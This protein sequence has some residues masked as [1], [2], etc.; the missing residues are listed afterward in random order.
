MAPEWLGGAVQRLYPALCRQH[1]SPRAG[2]RGGLPV[3]GSPVWRTCGPHAPD[4]E[5]PVFTYI[6]A[7]MAHVYAP[8]PA[9]SRRPARPV[10]RP[11]AR[12]PVR[13]CG[14]GAG[15]R[16]HQAG[17]HPRVRAARSLLGDTGGARRGS[18]GHGCCSTRLPRCRARSFSIASS[19]CSS[20]AGTVRGRSCRRTE[21]STRTCTQWRPISLRLTPPVTR[22]SLL[23]A[24]RRHR[25][26]RARVVQTRPSRYGGTGGR[27]ARVDAGLRRGAVRPGDERRMARRRRRR[28][29]L[30]D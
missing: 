15:G 27:S 1:G 25:R 29:R 18:T 13:L 5:K 21:V 2:G 8:G 6:T 30:H 28:L 24:L 4:L 9:G 3:E 14:S 7:R 12:R 19:D 16:R 22:G 23:R 17:L 26:T 10:A 20:I 11:R